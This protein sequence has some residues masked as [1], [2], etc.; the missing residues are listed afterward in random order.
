MLLTSSVLFF[1]RSLRHCR[2]LPIASRWRIRFL[3]QSY[4][5]R[6]LCY[7]PVPARGRSSG[8][9][10][11]RSRP[12]F[13]HPSRQ[14]LST[15]WQYRDQWGQPQRPVVLHGL[16]RARR[17]VRSP[18]DSRQQKLQQRQETQK[19]RRWRRQTRCGRFPGSCA[20]VLLSHGA[21]EEEP[22]R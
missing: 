21:Q 4:V 14:L 16:W 10:R 15:K 8:R 20:A 1:F 13:G 9:R 5:Q 6:P 19:V 12:G 7:A 11:Y 22:R 2:Q 3:R 18:E 17:H